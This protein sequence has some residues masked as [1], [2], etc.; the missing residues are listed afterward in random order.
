MQQ[1]LVE[2]SSGKY[3]RSTFLVIRDLI[4]KHQKIIALSE[5]IENLY[6][7]IALMQ[8]L[9]NTL[10]MCCTGFVII[11]V[12]NVGRFFDVL[13]N[14]SLF[15]LQIIS[16][17]EDTTNLIKSVSY[18][19]AIILD[20]FVYCFVGEFLSAKVCQ[21]VFLNILMALL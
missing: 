3:D 15:L 4:C 7:Y 5:N 17:G 6:T 2:I 9:W 12:S 16:S 1:D 8:V 19:I 13:G 14:A 20:V 21:R 10:V 18:Y 11:I